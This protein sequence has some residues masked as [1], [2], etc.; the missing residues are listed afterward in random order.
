MQSEFSIRVA[1]RLPVPAMYRD[2][3]CGRADSAVAIPIA[4]ICRG[5][6]QMIWEVLVLTGGRLTERRDRRRHACQVRQISMYVCHVALRMPMADIGLA[7]GRDR[8]TVSHACHVVEDRRDDPVFDE[9]VSAIER[10]STA[11]FGQTEGPLHD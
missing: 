10:I 5:V 6:R 3:A 2:A 9:F 4:R 7:F 8:S 11:A 1:G